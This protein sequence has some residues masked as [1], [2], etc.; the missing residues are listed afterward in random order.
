M[1]TAAALEA[2]HRAGSPVVHELLG[3]WARYENSTPG[4]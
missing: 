1:G 2:A 3:N 4:G